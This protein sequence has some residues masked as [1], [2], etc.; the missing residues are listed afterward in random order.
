MTAREERLHNDVAVAPLLRCLLHLVLHSATRVA[1]QLGED[2]LDD[3]RGLVQL[4]LV[5]DERRRQAD[6]VP[7]GRQRHAV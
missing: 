7:A 1:L 3:A 2:L 4:L 6:D 5:D